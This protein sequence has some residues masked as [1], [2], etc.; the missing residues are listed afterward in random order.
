VILF[1]I[2]Y[3]FLF[4]NL[5]LHIEENPKQ[6]LGEE[7]NNKGKRTKSQKT[8]VKSQKRNKLL[9]FNFENF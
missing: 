3:Y 5:F 8:K 7:L 2:A 4:I 9:N 1:G 6:E